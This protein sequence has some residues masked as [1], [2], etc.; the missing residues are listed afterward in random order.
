MLLHLNAWRLRSCTC[1]EEKFE[2]NFD[3]IV[4]SIS[5]PNPT[6][7]NVELELLNKHLAF[8]HRWTVLMW[9]DSKFHLLNLS[10]T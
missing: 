6:S 5:N 1:I 3:E 7:R 4:N 10:L 2:E 8:C 9:S